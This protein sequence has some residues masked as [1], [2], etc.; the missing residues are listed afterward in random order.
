VTLFRYPTIRALA[1]HLGRGGEETEAAGG[2]P[3]RKERANVRTDV[4]IIGMSGRFPGAENLDAFWQNLRLG[5]ES[6]SVFSEQ[7]LEQRDAALRSNPNYVKAG[8][9]LS[10]I[11]GFDAAFFDISP[12]EAAIMDPQQRIL[13]ECAWEA[14]E[15]AGYNPETY[16]G[17][18]GV[19]A[20][21]SLSTYLL[22][23][24]S[25]HFG[26]SADRP[27][28]E[29]DMLQFQVKLGNDR[30]YLPTRVSYKLN[31][32]GPSVNVQTACST[33]LVAVHLACQS[34]L[35]GEC[36]MALAGA[37]SIT[38]PHKGGYLYED[39]M[40]RSP[41]GHCRAFDAQAAGTLF[42]NGGG[43]VLLKRLND[44][45][46]DGDHIV[47]VVKGSAT[48]NDGSQKVG[49]TAPSVERQA[50]VIE[51][52]LASGSV[53]AS[54]VSYV[55]AHG[56]G[57]TL[58]DPIEIA[59]LAQAFLHSSAGELRPRHCAVGS[60]KTNIGHLDEAAGIAGL[61]KTALALRHKSI[62]PSLHFRQPNSQIDF[63]NTPFHVNTA[64]TEWAAGDTPR[65][66]GVSSFGMGG[67]NCHVVL[68]ESPATQATTTGRVDAPPR[69]AHVLTLS[70]RSADALRAVAERYVAHFTEHPDVPLAD[71]CFTANTGRKHF[72]QRL[73]VV[74]DSSEQMRARLAERL[75]TLGT[76]ERPASAT[77]KI[78][79][80]FTGQGSQYAD[81][82]REL[83]Q[84]QPVFRETLERCDAILRPF[85]PRPLLSVLFPPPAQSTPLDETAYTQPALFA[86]AYALTRVWKSWGIEPDIVLG[87]SVGEY[88]AACV[89]GVFSLE[90][91]LKLI[92]ERGRLMGLQPRDGSMVA[93]S[94]S[95]AFVAAFIQ[96]Y[97][98]QVSIAAIN[99]PESVV[100]SGHNAALEPICKAL[101]AQAVRFTRL[102]VSH[103]FHSPLMEPLVRSFE[104]AAR[105]VS[106]AEPRVEFISNVTG[107][108][109]GREVACA[110]YWVAHVRQPVRFAAGMESVARAG[111]DAYVEIGPKPILLQMGRQCL[112][113]TQGVWLPSWRR[114]GGWQELL[115]SLGELHLLGLP[116]NWFG[117][118]APYERR[119][120]P[121]PTYP[122]K[123]RR[124]W[125]DAPA[126]QQQ[127][128]TV[129][130]GE[131]TD[132]DGH[133]LVGRILHL[134]QSEEI[135]FQS[136]VGKASPSWLSDHRVFQSIV[137]PGVA[138]LEMAFAAGF[139]ALD[140]ERLG[141]VDFIIH[142]AMDWPDEDLSRTL[143]VIL[144]PE[145]DEEYVFRV[146]SR[147]NPATEAA[148]SSKPS[149]TL[150]ASGRLSTATPP[151]ATSLLETESLGSLQSRFTHEIFVGLIYEGERERDIDLG[152]SFWATERLWRHG[153][154]CL[155]KISLPEALLPDAAAYRIHP[156]LL[157]ACFLALTVTYPEK[158]GRRTYVPLG[159]ERL[160]I[161]P[162]AGTEMWC[163]A[164][165]RPAENDDPQ[166]LTADVRL[167][168]PDGRVVL[169]M[170]GVLLKIAHRE[171]MLTAPEAS[172]KNWLY[173]KTWHS[174]H[175]EQQ[176]TA[177]RVSGHWLILSDGVVGPALAELLRARGA[178][179]TLAFLEGQGVRL[180]QGQQT[181]AIDPDR[182]GAFQELLE[183]LQDTGGV[184][185]CWALE[186]AAT[187]S[188]DAAS[189]TQCGRL[190]HLVQALTTRR[191]APRL[192]LVSRG[193]QAVN[194]N[195]VRDPAG[196]A[197]WGVGQVI[198][199]EHPELGCVQI[200]LDPD[201]SAGEQAHTLFTEIA[202]SGAEG[203]G[204][205]DQVGFRGQ[206]RYVARLLRT[207]AEVAPK[208]R[209]T[210][211]E[212]GSYLIT[213]GLGGLGLRAAR[214]LV[215]RGARHLVLVGR[216]GADAAAA[217]AL[218]ELEQAG[219]RVVVNVANVSDPA[220]VARI[221]GEMEACE[222]LPPLRGVMHLAGVLD[223]GSLRRLSRQRFAD[224]MAPK[225]SG[226]WHLH[227]QTANLDL[228][229]FV[230]FS[231]VTSLLGTA[232]QA[233]YA[234]ANAFLDGL[235]SYRR[236]RGLPGLSINWGSW[237]ET[238]MS[239]RLGLEEALKRKGEGVIP[240]GPGISALEFLLMNPPA[241]G[242][243]AVLPADWPRFLE[244][245]VAVLPLLSR[246]LK[247]TQR[248]SA[249]GAAT[250]RAERETLRE[251]L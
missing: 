195:P 2:K 138:Y 97:E 72:E 39:G 73:A 101:E 134:A 189:V 146:F 148:P 241:G 156:V 36:D 211:R 121:L 56:T 26:Y 149:W 229:F 177:A 232:G 197:L 59:A 29:A 105:E 14:F 174:Q 63:D 165:L 154:S 113:E 223:D 133:P 129:E 132:R 106:Y 35:S 194:E 10:N 207:H 161:D 16:D 203:V 225:V 15:N 49:F 170:E 124:H 151:R 18:V 17:P 143:Q 190:L 221:L 110:D 236:A 186:S 226:A 172:W 122:W 55:E 168:A 51:D 46:A 183:T 247:T 5:V 9:V 40:I 234:A 24:V 204:R 185:N 21:S 86:F 251:R 179:C 130:S 184:V 208:G 180:P 69:P 1:E 87:H 159:V 96:P 120:V 4:A 155:S 12:K 65:R 227:E 239:A 235:A 158:Y 193:A 99:A 32:S 248:K 118:D 78:A 70:A 31:L 111:V 178:K 182:E 82:G 201:A 237:A 127:G 7:E 91:G 114:G 53:D 41:D 19:Y 67:T 115:T 27:L 43:L 163:H 217:S 250:R 30:N 243:V 160:H 142:Q 77:G 38:V 171:A 242:N 54:T 25:P 164:E 68:E 116:V 62:P 246:L 80:L 145:R 228:D 210:L 238:G 216:H 71:V 28:I 98:T 108:A 209:L 150:H 64:L 104:Q 95:E 3:R 93:V 233:N 20:G 167:F 23:N 44:A 52:A 57:T 88:V 231:S 202:S 123:R 181:C 8:A 218:R 100:I 103:A 6:I 137:M 84:T 66:A 141:L 198:A 219:A 42:G 11:E 147:P 135:R 81:M 76:D 244:K 249:G 79:F 126:R 157:E 112:P 162:Y 212:D 45:L 13:L 117:F 90:D 175:R 176:D 92:A 125:V 196:T 200:D 109:A 139:T 119:R 85:L 61:I 33:G 173:Q 152:P 89:A 166:T 222:E 245:Q 140:A 199:L 102:N 34:L 58:G 205:E 144:Q 22:N 191:Q 128:R 75:Q 240:P 224:V 94:A 153:T 131:Q 136:R 213:G 60:V 215:E 37:V 169:S 187:Q 220:E 47:A 206:T 50:A 230:C 214:L 48:N 83:Y 188:A 107:R 192:W 74:A